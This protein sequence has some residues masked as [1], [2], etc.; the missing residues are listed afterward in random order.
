M[1]HTET[2][3]V[4]SGRRGCATVTQ[5]VK[6]ALWSLLNIKRKGL[7]FPRLLFLINL[8]LLG[9]YYP[10]FGRY[11]IYDWFGIVAVLTGFGYYIIRGRFPALNRYVLLSGG[12][13]VLGAIVTIPNST[14]LSYSAFSAILMFYTLVLWLSLPDILFVEW[15]YLRWAFIALGISVSVTSIYAIGQKLLGFPVLGPN[16]FWGRQIG[17][18]RQPN[19]IGTFCAMVFP[20]LLSLTITSGT[21]R[22]NKIIWTSVAMLAVIGV[23][24]SGSMTGTLAL[25]A[26][27]SGYYFTTSCRGRVHTVIL[28][29]LGAIVIAGFSV[30][31]SGRDTQFVVQRIERFISSEHGKITLDQRLTANRH[32]WQYIQSNPLQ[33]YGYHTQVKSIGGSTEV[34]NTIL[35]AWYDGG[36]FTLLA[37][38]ILLSGAAIALAKAWK[39]IVYIGDVQ[40]KHYVAGAIGAFISFLVVTQASPVLYQRSAWFPVAL[41]FAV[42]SIVRRTTI[43]AHHEE[44]NGGV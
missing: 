7:W 4:A 6:L 43:A 24:L 10:K 9:M 44:R 18:T 19:E 42:A 33:G 27:I 16:Y 21:V 14:H 15:K 25:L 41:A 35:R 8:A 31:Y 39:R 37:V 23:L 40:H 38:L 29:L 11:A 28:I 22:R 34:H 2:Q 32:A 5:S 30:V 12:L 13:I 20:Y 26:G 17:L 3:V 1:S 36:I